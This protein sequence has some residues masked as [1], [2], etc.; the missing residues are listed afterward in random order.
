M[1]CVINEV[2]SNIDTHWN[3]LKFLCGY[4]KGL[5]DIGHCQNLAAHQCFELKHKKLAI[6]NDT[7]AQNYA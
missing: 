1:L 7:L 3:G 5:M 4:S 2:F 6:L